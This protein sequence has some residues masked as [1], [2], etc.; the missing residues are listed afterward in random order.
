M[1]TIKFN[2]NNISIVDGVPVIT[3]GDG[4]QHACRDC[5]NRR[6]KRR[7]EMAR[8]QN[9]LNDP[10]EMYKK[11]YGLTRPCS[12]CKEHKI[13]EEFNPSPSMENGLHNMCK[14]CCKHYGESVGDRW[15]VYMPDGNFKY[16]KTAQNMHD[17]HIFPLAC[18]GSNKEINHQLISSK[19]NLKK[20]AKIEFT[21][22][23]DIDKH[24]LSKRWRP[25][26]KES[27]KQNASIRILECAL[28][29]AIHNERVARYHLSDEELRKQFTAYNKKWNKRCNVDRAI[30]KYRKYCKEILKL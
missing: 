18:G 22:V 4:L 17:D 2:F 7:I 1:K 11:K 21:S 29:K 27:K 12:R 8:E 25:I 24:L 20:S 15:I 3:K 6:R 14:T 13:P 9:L 10:F 19:E 30:V 16:K 23:H 26:L 5:D 28:R